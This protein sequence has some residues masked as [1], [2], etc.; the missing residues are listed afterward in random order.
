MPLRKEHKNVLDRL[1]FGLWGDVE[2]VLRSDE[3]DDWRVI[4]A[5]TNPEKTEVVYVGDTEQGRD[6]RGR[7][8]AHMRDREKVSL[9][10]IDSDVYIHLMVTEFFVLSFEEEAGAM[11]VWPA[12]M[13]WSW[14]TPCACAGCGYER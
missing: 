1:Q 13:P 14:R 12:R 11:S 2:E 6:V 3:F 9:V 8:K 5:I 7:L 4:Y 10:E